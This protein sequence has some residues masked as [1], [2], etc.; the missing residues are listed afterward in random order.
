VPAE[1]GANFTLKVVL[2]P[3]VNVTGGVIPE[4]LNPV[5]DAATAEITMLAPP[6]FVMVSVWLEFCP[7]AML[8][9]V[10][11]VGDADAT[12]AIA[13]VPDSAISAVLLDPLKVSET[14]PL[15]GPA[16]VG[17]NFTPNVVSCPGAK[18]SG[19]LN[20]VTLKPA[21]VTVACEIVRLAP[22]EFCKVS[23]CVALLP[24]TTVPKMKL[25]GLVDN[26]PVTIPV[27]ASGTFRTLPVP[28]FVSAR[29][30]VRLP[31]D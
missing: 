16:A 9:K 23:V 28:V 29:L 13:P 24:T 21:P 31:T 4:M 2:C 12:A 19:R 17:P 25:L 30:P 18:V 7:T 1:V 10:M 15:T 3:A 8:V 14:C 5:P 6:V 11:L 26:T 22:P 27:P 20:P